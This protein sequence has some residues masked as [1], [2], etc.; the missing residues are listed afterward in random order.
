MKCMKRP[1][2]QTNQTEASFHAACLHAAW[3]VECE[4]FSFPPNSMKFPPNS[5]SN[6]S[7]PPNQGLDGVDDERGARPLSV[8]IMAWGK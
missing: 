5:K 4:S 8:F 2:P 1:A 6:L 3:N 7:F